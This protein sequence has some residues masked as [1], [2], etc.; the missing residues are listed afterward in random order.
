MSEKDGMEWN[1]RRH[2]VLGRVLVGNKAKLLSEKK[3]HLT[4]TQ[5]YEQSRIVPKRRAMAPYL[6]YD[7]YI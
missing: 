6:V 7:A 1:V 3:V 2:V 4:V 5:E